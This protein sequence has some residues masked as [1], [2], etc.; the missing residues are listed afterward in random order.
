MKPSFLFI[1]CQNGAE[2]PLKDEVALRYPDFRFAYSRRGF[3][4][5]R[6]PDDHNLP[7]RLRLG[8]TFART[9]GFSLGQVAVTTPEETAAEVWK[10]AEGLPVR[11]VHVWHRMGGVPTEE[12][13]GLES[14]TLAALL[15]AHPDPD[16]LDVGE[17]TQPD[18]FVLDC[19]VV[20]PDVWWVGFHRSTPG[21]GC[22][23]GGFYRQPL[24]DH[25]VSRAY[26]KVAEAL[27]WAQLPVRRGERCAEIGA[28]PGGSCQALLDRGLVVTGI[29][30]AKIHAN[31]IAHRNFTHVRKR[32]NEMKRRDFRRTRWLLADMNVAPQYTLDAIEEI[33]KH[34]ETTVRGVVLTLKMPD[35]KLARNLDA[36]LER[37]RT[38]GLPMCRP[39]TCITIAKRFALW[40]AIGRVPH[41]PLDI[42]VRS[43]GRKR[44]TFKT[45][46]L[47]M[48]PTMPRR[49]IRLNHPRLPVAKRC[50]QD[51]S[52]APSHCCFLTSG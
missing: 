13:T 21:P 34:D 16:L 20:E 10:L 47:P 23:P 9:S 8:L 46:K 12:T 40:H 6:L 14:S 2:T 51:D 37:V 17:N 22:W 28:A 49:P 32:G 4:T 33:V 38:W 35:W 1:G 48:W 15:A 3:V 50:N 24:P 11:S 43:I 18:T 19:V 45:T 27:D 42:G 41:V 52:D 29:D 7:S 30:P 39:G 5:Y 25:A 44:R 31:V 26:L 36:I